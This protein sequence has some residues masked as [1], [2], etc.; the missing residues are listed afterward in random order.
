MK[1]VKG[2]SKEYYRNLYAHKEFSSVDSAAEYLSKRYDQSKGHLAESI[3]ND[4]NCDAIYFDDNSVI[5]YV[6]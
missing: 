4:T 5:L 1:A 3:L 6:F 2:Y